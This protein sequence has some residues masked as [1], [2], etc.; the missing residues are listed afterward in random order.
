MCG[1]FEIVTQRLLKCV[2]SQKQSD[3][4]LWYSGARSLVAATSWKNTNLCRHLSKVRST[5]QFKPVQTG[6]TS[7]YDG[8]KK[9]RRTFHD[10]HASRFNA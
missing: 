8:D 9:S 6:T 3:L 5:Q 4:S 10:W 1:V 7:I 2:A